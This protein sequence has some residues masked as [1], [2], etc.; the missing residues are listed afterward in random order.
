MRYSGGYATLRHRL[1]SIAPP[2]LRSLPA[3]SL[4]TALQSLCNCI[5]LQSLILLSRRLEYQPLFRHSLDFLFTVV[6]REI[7]SFGPQRQQIAVM[8]AP[9]L[10]RLSR[11]T[12]GHRTIPIADVQDFAERRAVTLAESGAT[13]R[14]N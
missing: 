8:F 13:G 4:G 9:R 14:E 1:I 6:Q 11:N 3:V 5:Q 12:R 7:F 2:A 10:S